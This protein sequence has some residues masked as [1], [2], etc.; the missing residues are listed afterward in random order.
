M[1]LRPLLLLGPAWFVVAAAYVVT[2]RVTYDFE[3]EWLEGG[4]LIQMLRLL[5]GKPLYTAPDLSYVP[6]IYPPLYYYV[7]AAVSR[8][9]NDHSFT[10][11]RLVSV[12]ATMGTGFLIYRLV[13]EQSSS[14]FWGVIAVGIFAA[15]F[16]LGG[17]W[18]DI[19]RVDMLFIFLLV[20]GI[21]ALI[22]GWHLSG[23]VAGTLFAMAFFTKQTVLLPLV[24]VVVWLIL[25]RDWRTSLLLVGSF[26]GLSLVFFLIED[27]RTD[28]WYEY[29]V[30]LLPSLHRLPQPAA[31]A[32][33]AAAT[34][35]A[36]PLAIALVVASLPVLAEWRHGF[37]G[38]LGLLALVTLAAICISVAGNAQPG[39]YDNANVP[40]LAFISVLAA[41]GAHW[42]EIRRL[43]YVLPTLYILFLIQFG[44][45]SYNLAEQIPS[46]ADRRAGEGIV[47]TLSNTTGE[48]LVPY[49]PYLALLAGKR[50]SAHQVMLWVLSGNFGEPEMK[51]WPRLEAEISLK[52]DNR[53]FSRI[54]LDKPD[55]VWSKVP[56]YYEGTAIDY[57][58][59]DDFY[60]V[61]GGKGRPNLDYT[62]R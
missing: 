16:R 12:A 45:L 26:L 36:G 1:R 56:L 50:P 30:F 53:E 31:L 58:D 38:V 24:A 44:V 20:G 10:A 43:P 47:T 27:L 18:F 3:L 32:V 13:F 29:Y 6:F 23:L 39:G 22:R 48:V 15:T 17:A 21:Y 9:S 4:S 34:T 7:A 40:A 59:P 25:R 62:P 2:R 61:T 46:Q 19:A 41:L 55:Q 49:H 28:G 14:R 52:L 5:D 51:N 33:F 42:L 11:M 54:L 8:L 57:Q 35:L 37:R 60:P